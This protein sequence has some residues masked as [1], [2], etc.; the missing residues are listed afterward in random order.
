MPATSNY[1][2]IDATLSPSSQE[3]L[4]DAVRACHADDTPLYPIGGGA[5]LDYGLPGERPGA[6]LELAGLSRVV[7]YPARDMTITV[8]A[9]ATVQ[10]INDLLAGERQR[11]P[12][13]VP[14]ADRATVGGV[15]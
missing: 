14:H 4:A 1:L 5:S 3:E 13:D 7:D 6:A 10:A 8:E 2:P 12:L 15:V 11:L 9:G